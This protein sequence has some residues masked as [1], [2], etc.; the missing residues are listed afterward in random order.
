MARA[1]YLYLYLYSMRLAAL[2]Q[3]LLRRGDLRVPSFHG[4]IRLDG[5][6]PIVPSPVNQ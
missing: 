4:A 3:S 6:Q 2:T 5:R 1:T